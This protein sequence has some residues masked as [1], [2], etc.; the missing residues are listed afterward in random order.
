MGIEP[1]QSSKSARGARQAEVRA[2]VIIVYR[3][4]LSKDSNTYG[5]TPAISVLHTIKHV[6]Q[7]L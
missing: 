5:Y 2:P 1:K 7:A 4:F 3:R 6:V